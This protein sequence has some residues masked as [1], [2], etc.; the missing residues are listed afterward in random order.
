MFHDMRIGVDIRV[1]V[2]EARSGVEEYTASLLKEMIR[3]NKDDEFVLF[4]NA[5][6]KARADF[7]WMNK[8]NVSLKEF[9]LP[10]Q[11]FNYISHFG[12]PKIDKMIG[13][14]DVFFSPHFLFA[15]LSKDCKRVVTFHDLS[16][17]RYPEF[18]PLHKRYWHFLMNV[19][20]QAEQADKIIAISQSTKN[21]LV[22]LYG[23]DE[24]K[25]KVIY[26]GINSEFRPIENGM[27]AGQE[28]LLKTQTQA[29]PFLKAIP[30]RRA[31]YLKDIK[32]KYK[33]PDNFILY[34]GTI[35]PRKNIGAIIEAFEI[36]KENK[37]SPYDDLKL[38]IAGGFGWLYKD[39]LKLAKN[40]PFAGDVIFTGVVE[41]ADR[42][43]IY[44]L[45][46]LFVFPSF[47]EGFGFPPLEAMACGVPVITSNCSSL[48]ETA[49]EGA[50]MIDPYRPEEI[51]IAAR[52][53]FNDDRLRQ[54]LI[55]KGFEQVKKF[56]WE[57][58]A[59]ETLNFIKS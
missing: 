17:L 41:S 36:I 55:Q 46:K 15:A 47:F 20:K 18:F 12:F 59:K 42:V 49:G 1:L 24:N 43:G 28:S 37:L 50:L 5:F 19:K 14:V 57:K 31:G 26:S 58:C 2:K 4:F 45:A 23:I 25:I 33:L 35:E 11:I 7:D 54:M 34:L 10:N 13:G 9:H 56:S 16:F 52:E 21:D 39:I 30:D 29:Q 38:V 6:F 3:S 48:P 27:R 40:S 32:S 44:N 22:E 8:P 53:I 51:A